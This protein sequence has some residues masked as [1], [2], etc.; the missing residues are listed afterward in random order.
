MSSMGYLLNAL[1]GLSNVIHHC[2]GIRIW[3]FIHVGSKITEKR[4]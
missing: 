4:I 3:C 1:I 2:F